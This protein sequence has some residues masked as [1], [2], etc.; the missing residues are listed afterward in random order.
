MKSRLL[1]VLIL[2]IMIVN[3][4]KNERMSSLPLVINEIMAINNSTIQDEYNQY[5]GW[6]ELYNSGAEPINIGGFYISDNLDLLAKCKIPNDTSGKTIIL[7]DSFLIIWFDGQTDQGP[8]HTCCKLAGSGE[9][10][11]ITDK[12]GKTIIDY[13]TYGSQTTDYSIGRLPDGSDNWAQFDRPTPGF[14][15]QYVWPETGISLVINEIM[16]INNSTIQ[17]EYDQYDD[18]IELYNAGDDTIDI[19]GFYISDNLNLLTKCKIPTNYPDSTKIAPRGFLIIWFD[20]QTDQGPLHTCCKLAGSGEDV[21]ITDK[22]GKTIIDYYTY[23]SQ[24]TD[25]SI[26]RSPDGSDNWIEYDKPTPGFSNQY[27]WPE[28]GSSLVI[29]EIMA[30]NKSAV[31]DEY[32]EFDDWIELYNAGD[33]TIDIGGFYIS[34]NLN[35]LTKCKI[36]TNYPDS[37]KIAP[38][39]FLIIWFD[40]QT[41]QGPLHTCSKL[42]G[43]G[44]DVV[45]TD[46]DGKTIIDYYTYGSQT[47][48][49]SFGRLPDGSDNWVQF[50]KPTPGASNQ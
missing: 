18:W 4:E 12:D 26:G 19:G 9:D 38:H 24:T 27:V 14:S 36:P 45:I 44:E 7:P 33:D 35:L 39:G 22:D 40:G 23:G 16:A 17:D 1:L 42:S 46:K 3:C 25:H 50:Y 41:D 34:D 43:S 21:V 20:G 48:D 5:D 31:Q 13:Y 8:L 28:I 30:L 2:I 47:T 32:K 49:Y 37:T 10:V 29:N 6:I 15:N 11:V